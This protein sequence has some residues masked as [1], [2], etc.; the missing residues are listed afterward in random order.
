MLIVSNADGRTRY[1]LRCHLG[2]IEL[3]VNEAQ[4]KLA[5]AVVARIETVVCFVI[6]NLFCFSK[7][8]FCILI[9]FFFV[10]LPWL[11]RCR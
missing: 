6:F 8:L 5:R 3:H 2:A 4:I 11:R 10:R 7:V 1:T 9:F